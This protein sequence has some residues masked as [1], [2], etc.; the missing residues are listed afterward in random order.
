MPYRCIQCDYALDG[1]VAA[2]HLAPEQQAVVCPECGLRQVP[3]DR[4]RIVHERDARFVVATAAPWTIPLALVFLYALSTSDLLEGIIGTAL[5]IAP[6][7][8]AALGVRALVLSR[9]PRVPP[10]QYLVFY[11]LVWLWISFVGFVACAALMFFLRFM[12]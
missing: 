1:L 2:D 8:G 11:P 5:L 10:F 6:A 9:H 7:V 3:G 4:D 12:P